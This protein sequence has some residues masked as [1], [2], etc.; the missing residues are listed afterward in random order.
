MKLSV[1]VLGL[2]ISS[3]SFATTVLNN[4]TLSGLPTLSKSYAR[5]A[6]TASEAESM[7]ASMAFYCNQ[8]MTQAVAYVQ[9]IGSKVLVTEGCK[10]DVKDNTFPC[11][12]GG[13]GT[14]IEVTTGFE[15]TF[16]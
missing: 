15:V 9:R 1:L 12:Q 3:A 10:V 11:D 4:I 5:T 6:Q 7:K 16:K 14:G 2:A 8:D 13:C